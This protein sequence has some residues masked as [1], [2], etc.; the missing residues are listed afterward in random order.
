MNFGKKI[1]YGTVTNSI[2]LAAALFHIG[3]PIQAG[4]VA[5]IVITEIIRKDY[6]IEK[7]SNWPPQTQKLLMPSI[8]TCFLVFLYLLTAHNIK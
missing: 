6:Y 3:L 7:F 1:F 8:I 5:I 4:V 2:L